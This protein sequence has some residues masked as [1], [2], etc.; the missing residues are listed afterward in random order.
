VRHAL[1]RLDWRSRRR[2][3]I[4]GD[5]KLLVERDLGAG[6]VPHAPEVLEQSLAYTCN[7]CGA[8]NVARVATLER[9]TRSCRRCGSTVRSRSIIDLLSRALFGAS[10]PIPHFPRDYDR[11]GIGLS[12]AAVYAQRLV[13]KLAYVNTY[14]H[15]PP[16][17]DI[18]APDPVLRD[19][20][21]FVLAS[22]VLEHVVPPV[23]SAFAGIHS[24]LRANGVLVGSVP[25]SMRQAT[26]EHFPHL[27]D[28][29]IDGKPGARRLHNR[30]RDGVEETFDQLVFHGGDGAT[31]EMREFSRASLTAELEKAGFSR[32]RFAEQDVYEFGIVWLKPWSIPFV[33][34][35]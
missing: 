26:I 23:E 2:E 1:D 29:R 3:E 4:P 19:S 28:F 6:W 34:F 14:Y 30:R 7:I 12:D 35:K 33:A 9:E 13:R 24:V 31:L 11:C 8:A 21:D 10:L 16:R 22:D 32:I 15:Q 27:H 20:C 5:F 25:Y 18:C 17:L